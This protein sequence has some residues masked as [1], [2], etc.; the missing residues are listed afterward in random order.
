MFA[1]VWTSPAE[2]VYSTAVNPELIF[3]LDEFLQ[4]LLLFQV[5]R[6]NVELLA[7]LLLSCREN[8]DEVEVFRAEVF[9]NFAAR[10]NVRCEVV[11]QQQ[12]EGAFFLELSV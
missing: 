11:V 12:R 5:R 10:P 8:L 3:F 2:S 9:E 4:C 6:F 7:K 1:A